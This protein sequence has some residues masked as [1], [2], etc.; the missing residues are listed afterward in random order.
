MALPGVRFA[1]WAP[2]AER[3]SVVG[4][5]CQWDGRR[6]PMR[7]LGSSGVWELFVPGLGAGEIYKFEIRSRHNGTI[8]LK[9]DPCARAAE[10]RPATASIVTA[11]S[12]FEWH[13]MEVD[14]AT[15]GARLAARAD[16]HLRGA[17]RL[18]ASRMPTA[19]SSTIARSRTSSHLYAQRLGFT[20]IELLP[21][22]EHPL[23][24]SWGYQTTGHF[25]PTSRHGSPDDLRYLIDQCHARGI[26]VLLD[27]VPAHFPRDA[28][29]LA[30]FDGTALY[31][32]R[33]SAQGRAQGLGHARLQLR[34]P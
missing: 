10:L 22:A 29:G 16:E 20:H 6:Y 14:R 5:F 26:G 25:A 4:P 23:D 2:D 1:V 21:I 30:S 27:W 24:D 7:V 8:L 3:V 13:D 34:A 31:E 33:R 17:P 9:A 32:Y 18:V 12:S 11:P 15:R 28:H 19:A